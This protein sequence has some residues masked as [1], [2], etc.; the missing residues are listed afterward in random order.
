M[1]VQQLERLLHLE[2][3]HHRGDRRRRRDLPR[4]DVL[5]TQQRAA[6]AQVQELIIALGHGAF[7]AGRVG[8]DEDLDHALDLLDAR[9]DPGR[10]DLPALAVDPE[11][12]LAVIQAADDEVDV[13][14]GA[15]AQVGDH[16]AVQR[17]DPDLGVQLAGAERGD[18]GLGAAAVLGPEQHRARQVRR[19]DDVQ[20]DHVDRAQADQRQVLQDLVAQRTGADDEHPRRLEPLLPPPGD[21]PQA[22]VSVQVVD[23]QRIGVGDG[24]RRLGAAE[25]GLAR[26]SCEFRGGPRR[27]GSSS[28]ARERGPGPPYSMKTIS[29]LGRSRPAAR[30]AAISRRTS[31]GDVDGLRVGGAARVARRPGEQGPG[32]RAFR[33]RGRLAV[34]GRSRPAVR[35]PG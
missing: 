22:A 3:R 28:R 32:R 34:A 10:A 15:Q 19:L 27:V 5:A 8:R 25:I 16:V 1:P 7:V 13:G 11:P 23:D 31:G 9:V 14:E 33:R 21:Q 2:R 4:R 24:R 26:A 29:S 18:L 20:V 35:A 17:D 12:G 6:I 30:L